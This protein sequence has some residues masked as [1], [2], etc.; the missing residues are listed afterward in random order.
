VADK[1]LAWKVG[2][3]TVLMISGVLFAVMDSISEG[4]KSHAKH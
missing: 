4:T 2:I 3:H 1:Q